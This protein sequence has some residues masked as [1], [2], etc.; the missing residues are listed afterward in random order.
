[1]RLSLLVLVTCFVLVSACDAPHGDMQES[2]AHD[3]LAQARDGETQVAGQQSTEQLSDALPREGFANSLGMKFVRIPAGEFIMG[4]KPSEQGVQYTEM[5]PHKVRITK[6]FYMGVYEVT[7]SEY[8][9]V[10]QVNPCE[11]HKFDYSMVGSDYPVAWVSWFDAVT[12]CETLSAIEKK[13]YRLPTEAEWEYA[14]R[15]GTTTRYSFGDSEDDLA[16]YAWYGLGYYGQPED[17]V[18]PP[19]ENYARQVGQKRPNPWGLYDMHG[20]LYEWCADNFSPSYYHE[21]PTEDP[22]GPSKGSGRV[23]RGG[24]FSFDASLCRSAFRDFDSPVFPSRGRGF[25]VVLESPSDVPD[26]R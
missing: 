22:Q 10:M 9:K 25:R 12:F 14:C 3:G 2:V 13:R 7:Q 19:S 16:D 6:P 18:P 11:D 23:Y 5:P 17:K 21:S 26:E 4:A 1:M 24:V 20:N 15:A 8:E